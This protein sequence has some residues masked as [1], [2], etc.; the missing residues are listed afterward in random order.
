MLEKE[1]LHGPKPDWLV[2]CSLADRLKV[3]PKRI[4]NWFKNR[5]GTRQRRQ[6]RERGL[7]HDVIFDRRSC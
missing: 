2:R 1:F 5:Q 4:K 6:E 7:S 3:P